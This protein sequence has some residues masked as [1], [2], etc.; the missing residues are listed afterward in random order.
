[1]GCKLWLMVLDMVQVFQQQVWERSIKDSP[2]INSSARINDTRER[3]NIAF[4]LHAFSLDTEKLN[5][6]YRF[7]IYALNAIRASATYKGFADYLNEINVDSECPSNVNFI[8]YRLGV[9]KAAEFYREHHHKRPQLL[10]L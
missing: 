9:E 5:Q 10:L 3:E 4:Y 1:M 8:D 2:N 7:G 6:E